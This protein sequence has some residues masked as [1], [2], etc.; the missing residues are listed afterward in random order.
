MDVYE[1]TIEN[2]NIYSGKI[3]NLDIETV[4][5]PNNKI[6][7][8]EIVRHPGAV[9]IVPIDD[10]GNICFVDQFRKAI[11]TELL[12]IPAGKLEK[13]EEPAL[14]ALRELQEEIGYSANKLTF[15][16]AIYTSPGFADEKIYIYKAE[17]LFKSELEKDEDEFINIV[18]YK[19]EKAFEMIKNGEIRDAK[20]IVAL[21]TA[22]K[23]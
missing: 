21:F 2:D 7:C 17:D 22:F 12:E 6:S 4:L 15:L 19:P 3:I 13:G 8:R 9:A 5:L 10:S 11:D 14:C 23:L 16:T 20:T 18:R 1:K